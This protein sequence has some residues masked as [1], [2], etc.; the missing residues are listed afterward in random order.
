MFNNWYK[1][2][3]PIQGMMGFG[4]GAASNL[5]STAQASPFS[6]TGGVTS[7]P[8]DGYRYH[9]FKSGPNPFVID[10]SYGGDA[11]GLEIMVIAGGGGGGNRTGGGG[12][13][14]GVA[15]ANNIPEGTIPSN[16]AGDDIDV[17]VG[18]AG[19]PGPG[20]GNDSTWA[21]GQPWSVFAQGG[22]TGGT[23]G[24]PSGAGGSGGGAHYSAPVGTGQ[25]PSQNPGKPWVTNYGNPGS[26]GYTPHPWESGGG[27]G[28]GSRGNDGGSGYR[29]Q[30]GNGISMPSFPSP[31]FCPPSDPW[32]SDLSGR[33]GPLTYYGGGGGGG[34]Y[35]PYSGRNDPTLALQGGGAQGAPGGGSAGNG[36]H[37]T[38]GGGGGTCDGPN[39]APGGRGG[40]GIVVIRYPI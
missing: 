28:A 4:G 20:N 39:G 12:G 8:G 13:A 26:N 40:H 3:K 29:G 22:G 11:T 14:G 18:S 16:V 31:K 6:G 25:Q 21:V 35:P 7:T 27:G 33:G 32:H 15:F 2:E 24:V 23:D 34:S 5:V 1:K 9:M 38:G 19:G 10:P 17:N 30:S 36:R 37:G